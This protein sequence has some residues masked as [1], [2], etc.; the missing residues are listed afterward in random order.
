MHPTLKACFALC[1]S[2]VS[3]SLA[4]DAESEIRSALDVTAS[5]W[6]EG[7]V[8]TIADY[9]HKDFVLVSQDGV[10]SRQQHLDEL[11][12]IVSAGEDQGALNHSNIR[13]TPLDEDHALAYGRRTL[14]F[15]DG[16]NMSNWFTTVY[17]RTPFGWKA[18]HQQN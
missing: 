12:D 10:V 3:A 11:R 9:Y 7:Q 18:V 15:A 17:L 6:S 13:V 4:A 14:V 1:A 2:L 5:L 16:S 8:D